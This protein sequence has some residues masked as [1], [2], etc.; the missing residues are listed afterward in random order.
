MAIRVHFSGE[1]FARTRIRQ[2]LSPVLELNSVVRELH[3]R[4]AAGR[5][6]GP[7][8]QEG[9]RSARRMQ[10]LFDLIPQRG[11][12]PELIEALPVRRSPA[13]GAVWELRAVTG[14]RL[15]RETELME[16]RRPRPLPGWIRRLGDDP[17]LAEEL[18]ALVRHTFEAFLAPRW[19][20]L[21][22]L[23]RTAQATHTRRLAEEGLEAVLPRLNPGL[24]CWRPPVLEVRVGSGHAEDVHLDGRGLT[25]VPRVL[26]GTRPALSPTDERLWLTV[27]VAGPGPALRP[28]AEPTA[29]RTPRALA[30]LLGA[31]RA[32]VLWVIAHEPGSTTGEIARQVNIAPSSASEH[33]GVLRD[34][35]LT[36]AHRHRNTV[37][38]S[39]APAG[40]ALVQAHLA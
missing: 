22:T 33:A 15:L 32:A 25:I 14:D 1:D 11:W 31:T 36:V 13:H 23:T 19:H 34:A 8:E 28:A 18:S 29:P 21:E 27:P 5:A 40:A 20:G 6:D 35:G 37:R 12:T 17:G 16:R 3:R 24:I 26:G 30:L 9:P 10:M 7:A 4:A 2:E 38:H 39:L